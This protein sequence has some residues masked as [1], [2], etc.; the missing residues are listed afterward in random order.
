MYR[1]A[2]LKPNHPMDLR[3]YQTRI[4]REYI[5]LYDLYGFYHHY[6][7]IQP[8]TITTTQ[9]QPPSTKCTITPPLSA[10][11][12][13]QFVFLFRCIFA[14]SALCSLLILIYLFLSTDAI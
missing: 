7:H 12:A 5:Q 9:R 13:H 2:N 4:D 11:R 14:I 10:I 3:L 6:H 1:P 8:T